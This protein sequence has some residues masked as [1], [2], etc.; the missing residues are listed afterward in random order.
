[1]VHIMLDVKQPLGACL[2]DQ[3]SLIEQS[4]LIEQSSF[5]STDVWVLEITYY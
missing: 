3:S 2:I 5:S 1:L 4:R